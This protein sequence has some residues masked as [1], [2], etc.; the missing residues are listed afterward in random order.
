MIPKSLS[1]SSL[2]VFQLCPSRWVVENAE[3]SKGIG[4]SAASTGTACHG[5]LEEYVK[6]CYLEGREPPTL[7]LLLDF[8][9]LSYAQTFNS[10]DYSTPEYLDGLQM[11]TDWHGKMNFDGFRVLLCETKLNFEIPTSAGPITFNYIFDRF[12]QLSETEFRVVDY[13]TNRWNTSPAE[14]QR[15]VQPRVYALAAAILLKQWGWNWTKIWVQFDL[16]RHGRVGI[17]LTR[18]DNKITW[19][20]IKDSAETIIAM[21]PAEA[22]EK[23]NPECRFCTKKTTCTELKKNID[24]GGIFSLSTIEEKMDLRAK[25]EWQMNALGALVA[26]VD[27][28]IIAEARGRDLTE[29]ESDETKL[30][31]TMSSTRGIDPEMVHMA[32]GDS[33]WTKY[34]EEK[35]TMGTVDKM[36]KANDLTVEQKA[37][38]RSLIYNKVGDPKVKVESKVVFDE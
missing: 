17:V 19:Q 27:K 26:E 14:L 8:F 20:F 6:A 34:G 25:I 16:L 9:K 7:E 28:Q 29:Y 1:A 12:D 13:K 23:L 21:D 33:L 30:R 18:D 31:I 5:A 2:N 37:S 15:K 24:T 11:L 36:L 38:V 35:I 3:R 4:N 10:F 32:V 22:E